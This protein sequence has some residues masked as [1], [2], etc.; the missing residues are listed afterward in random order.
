MRPK[1]R[2]EQGKGAEVGPGFLSW[3]FT[4]LI[5]IEQVIP[6]LEVL[7]FYLQGGHDDEACFLEMFQEIIKSL[8]N[9]HKWRPEFGTSLWAGGMHGA[10]LAQTP[11]QG[12]HMEKE[13]KRSQELVHSPAAR[14]R[15]GLCTFRVGDQGTMQLPP[16]VTASST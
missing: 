16:A 2:E 13:P 7:T 6:P 10:L 15:M 9:T 1:Q 11:W 8:I 3:P 5:L 14:L 4:N 12:E